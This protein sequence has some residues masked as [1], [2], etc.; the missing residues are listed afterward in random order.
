MAAAY[1]YAG[2]TTHTHTHTHQGAELVEPQLLSGMDQVFVQDQCTRH[3]LDT[4][5]AFQTACFSDGL[6]KRLFSAPE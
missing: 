6:L 1:V 3:A 5:R 2:L 4:L